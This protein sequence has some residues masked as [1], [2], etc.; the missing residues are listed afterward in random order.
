MNAELVCSLFVDAAALSKESLADVLACCERVRGDGLDL[1]VRER[2]PEEIVPGL[3][4]PEDF[5]GFAL[6]VELY[7][8]AGAEAPVAAVA[9]VLRT[10][11][12]HGVRAVASCDFEQALPNAGGLLHR[13]ETPGTG[14]RGT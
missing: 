1:E 6:V 13:P 3:P 7:G 11:W 4:F 8:P 9:E 14:T 2:K 10:V 12:S 5:F